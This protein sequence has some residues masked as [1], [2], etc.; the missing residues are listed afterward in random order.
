MR[1][2]GMLR[3]KLPFW[4]GFHNG[5]WEYSHIC[6]LCGSHSQLRGISETKCSC[7]LKN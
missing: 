1:L 4:D 3:V 6:N 5:A 7:S 2:R